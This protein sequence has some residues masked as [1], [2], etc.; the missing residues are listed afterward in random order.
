MKK[1]LAYYKVS[2]RELTAW[3]ADFFLS[4]SFNLVFFY[5]FMAIWTSI[6]KEGGIS[7]IADYSLSNTITYYFV[8]TI[9][10]RMDVS[11][12]IYLGN[13]IWNGNFTNDLIKPW[14]VKFIDALFSL[15]NVSVALILFLPFCLFIYL[16]AHQFINLPNEINLIF[17][18]ITLILVMIMNIFF[19][20]LFQALTFHYGDQEA[21]ISLINYV[22]MFLAGGMFPLAFL[23][24]NIK[25]FF[26]ILPF[27][28]MFD[29]PAN[30]FLGKLSSYEVFISWG[31]ILIWIGLFYL[32]YSIIFKSGLKKYTG[33]GR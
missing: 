27:R 18:I 11:D 25:W 12:S 4:T 10:F 2:F 21:N 28:F 9:I 1:Y 23:P 8:T 29:F 7:N 14:K 32:I 13:G 31:Q 26:D 19:S 6:Y 17:F 15:A 33:T 22:A 20:L 24:S 16:T 3:K 5:I 30:I